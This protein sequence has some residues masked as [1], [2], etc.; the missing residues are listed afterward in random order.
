MEANLRGLL[1][2]VLIGLAWA[3]QAAAPATPP[4]EF[5]VWSLTA[6]LASAAEIASGSRDADFTGLHSHSRGDANWFKLRAIERFSGV[7]EQLA[8]CLNQSQRA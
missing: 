6:P 2:M 4:V 1:A 7:R 8:Q 5:D 3:A